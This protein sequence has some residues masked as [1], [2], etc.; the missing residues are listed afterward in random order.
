VP[1]YVVYP[2]SKLLPT[3]VRKLIDYLAENLPNAAHRL[4]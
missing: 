4:R 2:S 3:R 1:L